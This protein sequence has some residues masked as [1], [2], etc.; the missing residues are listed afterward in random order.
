VTT[1]RVC[2]RNWRNVTQSDGTVSAGALRA[3]SL[4]AGKR[5][6]GE[7]K[8][9]GI[10]GKKDFSRWAKSR[11]MEMGGKKIAENSRPFVESINSHP[12]GKE[13]AVGC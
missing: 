13:W 10:S 5:L 6:Q 2:V 12:T 7:L 8:E 9:R 3:R 11:S 1:E 4:T